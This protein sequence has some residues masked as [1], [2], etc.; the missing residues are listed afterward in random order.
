MPTPSSTPMTPPMPT[1]S[2][3]PTT[4]PILM[5]ATPSSPMSL[6]RVHVKSSARDEGIG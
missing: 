5:L 3:T 2:S 1:P 4:P 6:A